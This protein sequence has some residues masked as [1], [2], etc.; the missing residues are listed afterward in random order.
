[1]VQTPTNFTSGGTAHTLGSYQQIVASTAQPVAGMWISADASV[2]ASATDTGMLMNIA[3]GASGSEVIQVTNIPFGAHGQQVFTYIPLYVPQGVE[4]RG[5][6]RATQI[7]D[8]YDP[9]ITLVYGGR[10]GAFGGYSIA[11]TIGVNTATSGPTTGDLTDNAWDEAVASTA[12]AYRA[13]TLHICLPPADTAAQSGTFTV[14]VG[15]GAAG[16]EQALATWTVE[17]TTNEFVEESFGPIFIEAEIPSG[18]RLALR[19]NSTNDHSGALI[20]WA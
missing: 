14:D 1:V 16:V 11:D 18:S 2:G 8:I 5:Q 12:Q 20:G 19:K 13:L 17:T 6:V 4:I 15:V 7:S 9:R 3:F 10:A